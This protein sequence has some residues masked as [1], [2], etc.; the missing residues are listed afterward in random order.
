MTTCRQSIFTYAKN[1]LS[2]LQNSTLDTTAC[3]L[4]ALQAM[5]YF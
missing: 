2:P 4:Y 3:M 5:P 1:V